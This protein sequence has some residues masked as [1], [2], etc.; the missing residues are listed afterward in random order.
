M[1]AKEFIVKN[2]LEEFQLLKDFV[3]RGLTVPAF[4]A[5]EDAI[6]TCEKKVLAL[7][8]LKII[9]MEEGEV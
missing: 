9:I 7:E 8:E 3:S 4:M 2:R 1:T 6:T 5:C